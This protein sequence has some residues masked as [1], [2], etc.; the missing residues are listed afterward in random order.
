MRSIKSI[1]LSMALAIGALTAC[2]NHKSAST[3]ADT[4]P[5]TAALLKHLK[6]QAATGYMFGQHDATLYG[7][8]WKGEK[9]RS[10]VKNVCGDYPAVISFDLGHIEHGAT[11][12]LDSVPFDD[13]RQAII[14]Q[15]NRGGVVSISWHVDNPLTGGTAWDVTDSNV[16]ASVL[17]GGINEA[18]FHGWLQRVATFL[19]SLQTADG[20][21]VPVIFRPWHEHTGS[22]FWWGQKLCT[23][24][25]YIALWELTDKTLKEEGVNNVLLAYSPGGDAEDYMERYPGDE[26]IDLLG[27]DSYQYNGAQ[28]EEAFIQAIQRN[29]SIMDAYCK[30]H[31]KAYAV[32]EAGYEGIPDSTWWTR[33]LDKAIGSYNPS[34]VL[35][36]RNACDKEGHYFAPYPGQQS[37]SDFMEFYQL[38]RTLFLKDIENMYVNEVKK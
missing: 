26:L 5:Q 36:W 12:S 1:I 23:K 25:Q 14:D 2:Q 31:D 24:E 28:G 11:H 27:F 33:V 9:E 4:T 30:E 38:P 19:N 35:I 32:T 18:K 37:E 17:T 3:N 6:S 34:Y 29:L 8:G 20:T 7:V 21:K 13:I 22:W 16:V 10:D 15:Y